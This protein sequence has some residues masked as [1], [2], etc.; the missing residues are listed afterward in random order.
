MERQFYFEFGVFDTVDLSEGRYPRLLRCVGVELAIPTEM[1]R[2]N[3]NPHKEVSRQLL[4]ILDQSERAQVVGNAPYLD[5]ARCCAQCGG[6]LG[7]SQC[8]TCGNTFHD[9][10]VS[11]SDGIGLPQRVMNHLKR[12]GHRFV[13][14]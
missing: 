7:L 5:R 4:R 2:N 6:A 3:R 13:S 8:S 11:A 14:V 12:Q 10:G 1:V 9:D